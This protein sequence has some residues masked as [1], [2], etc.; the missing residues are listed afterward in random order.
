MSENSPNR[1]WLLRYVAGELPED[2]I[3][4]AD[5]RF[6]AIDEFAA[7]VDGQYRDLLDAYAAGEITGSDKERVEKIF[8]GE[9]EQR[10]Q[11]KI[12]AAMQARPE[13]VSEP[14]R[15]GMENRIFSFWPM[16]ISAG[17]LSFAIAI[18]AFQHNSRL[19]AITDRNAPAAKAANEPPVNEPVAPALVPAESVFTI[20]LLPNVSRGAEGAKTFA[21]P[22]KAGRIVIQVVLPPGQEGSEFE[23]RLNANG[24]SEPRVFSSLAAK[25][26][27][28]QKYV[29]F[30]LPSDELPA[31]NYEL[32]IFRAGAAGAAIEQFELI[33]KRAGSGRQ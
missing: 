10:R 28:T 24:Q 2:D 6:F 30:S 26:I 3:R 7:A 12:L 21:I 5:E 15:R 13:R 25:T 9:P 11:L 32:K 8:L 18:V 19:Q 31:G 33:A 16:A 22:E 1:E 17:V 23:V 27:E 29:E 20:L 14:A 4:V